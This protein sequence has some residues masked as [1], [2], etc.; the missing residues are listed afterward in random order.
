MEDDKRLLFLWHH[1][2]IL[3]FFS[4]FFFLDGDF[5]LDVNVSVLRDADDVGQLDSESRSLIKVVN[6]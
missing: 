6:G 5:K 1:L 2:Q 4:Y 3:F